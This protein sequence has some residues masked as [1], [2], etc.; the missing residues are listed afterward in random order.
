MDGTITFG[1]VACNPDTGADIN[2]D[3]SV[4]FPDFLILSANFGQ[5][6]LSGASHELGDLDCS[7]DVAFADFLALSA[8]FGSEVGAQA[9]PEPSSVTLLGLGAFLLG[10]ARRSRK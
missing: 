1:A 10:V 5:T 7:G 6:G 9:V 8:A 4:G 3:G 2:G